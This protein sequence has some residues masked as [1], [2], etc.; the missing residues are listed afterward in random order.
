MLKIVHLKQF[1]Q[2]FII[3][4]EPFFLHGICKKVLKIVHFKQ[5]EQFFI[6]FNI[7]VFSSY[8]MQKIAKN[9]ENSAFIAI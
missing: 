8:N 7:T 1:E 9:A 5:F 4:K 2:F 3:F 6:I